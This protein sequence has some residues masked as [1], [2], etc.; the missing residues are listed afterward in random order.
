MRHFTI[1]KQNKVKL[2]KLLRFAI[3]M[4][5]RGNFCVI[6]GLDNTDNNKCCSLIEDDFETKDAPDN[7]HHISSLYLAATNDL[8]NEI[9]ALS[10]C[11]FCQYCGLGDRDNSPLSEHDVEIHL[12]TPGSEC[13]EIYKDVKER[14]QMTKTATKYELSKLV[15]CKPER[16]KAI[17]GGMSSAPVSPHTENK[18]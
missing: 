6:C 15:P 11:Y 17:Y 8:Q 13:Y 14:K 5:S 16:Q 1:N 18:K 12:N 10:K 3:T 2:F 9:D 4:T 7:Q